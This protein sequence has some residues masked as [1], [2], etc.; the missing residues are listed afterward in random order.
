MTWKFNPNV[1]YINIIFKAYC[2]V[3]SNDCSFV[4]I[5]NVTILLEYNVYMK[6]EER[7]TEVGKQ[8][9]KISK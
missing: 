3:K 2:K 1:C 5:V 7:N 6:K 8:P 9:R 4:R